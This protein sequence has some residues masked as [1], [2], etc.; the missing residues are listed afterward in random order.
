MIVAAILADD[1]RDERDDVMVPAERGKGDQV[2]AGR[3]R[4][5]GIGRLLVLTI[6]GFA[7]VCGA[8]HADT[9][10]LT[11]TNT[12]GQIDPAANLP[13][14]FTISGDAAIPENLYVKD[15]APGGAPCAPSAHSDSG[16]ELHW[17]WWGTEVNGDF[18]FS[19]VETWP[20]PG[21][22]MFCMW[23][24]PSGEEPTTPISELITFRPAT[25]NLSAVVTP[26]S[27]SP[28]QPAEFTITGES[29]APAELFATVKPAGGAGCAPSYE[30]DGGQSV[31]DGAN[32]NGAFA[33]HATHNGDQAGTYE[34]CSWLA[35]G[36]S[37]AP[38]IA[39]PQSVIFTVG[40]PP[41]P[42]PACVV[43]SFKTYT[44][45]NALKHRIA[46]AH[47]RVGRL[48][49]T[50][51]RHIQHGGIVALTPGT[52]AILTSDAS[53]SIVISLGRR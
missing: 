14:V 34:L 28:G 13:R 18:S 2:G 17:G 50:R 26:A 31:V 38:A 29:E 12:A 45:L 1:S 5:Y 25:G 30:A 43:P 19:F 7:V 37:V 3:R 48:R 4:R 41:P 21:T 33:E 9:A 52:H 6:A 53:V 16:S 40:A 22:V 32:V 27:P 10:S 47:C 49:Y 35:S 36:P 23:L 42:P 11:V 20:N 44:P 15:R 51:S 24:E 39:G 46:A 8:A